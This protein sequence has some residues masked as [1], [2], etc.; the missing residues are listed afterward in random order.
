MTTTKQRFCLHLAVI[1]LRDPEL[2]KRMMS[3]TDLTWDM[4]KTS[5]NALT[6][7]SESDHKLSK[8]AA[9]AD[10]TV[11]QEPQ[12]VAV[13]YERRSRGSSSERSYNRNSRG[14][15]AR[16]PQRD[17]GR[18]YYRETGRYDRESSEERVY[19]PRSSPAKE[20]RGN[21]SYQ[22]SRSPN[23]MRSD[24]SGSE[25]EK[26][27]FECQDSE[28][29]AREC[30]NPIC[31]RCGIRGHRSYNCPKVNLRDRGYRRSGRSPDYRRDGNSRSYYEGSL[32]S[33]ASGYASRDS[34]YR[35]SRN[36][37]PDRG[38]ST[39]RRDSQGERRS[40]EERSPEQKVRF[41]REVAD[42]GGYRDNQ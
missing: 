7:A 2:R 31:Y 41:V 19:S 35:D 42:D 38:S 39:Y 20:R 14:Y 26:L 27:C 18:R 9:A 12:E 5:L 37:S 3:K 1:G 22:R 36:R 8:A 40:R 15:E 11:K 16:S 34:S 32:R 25:G 4:L 30:P 28:H 6:R 21:A 23:R 13:V 29:L 10:V 17:K 33:E 24:S